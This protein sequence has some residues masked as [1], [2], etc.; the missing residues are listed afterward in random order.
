MPKVCDILSVRGGESDLGFPV[1]LYADD[2]TGRLQI[3]GINE[4]GFA[5]VDIDVGD[6]IQWLEQLAPGAIDCAAL[7]LAL[8]AAEAE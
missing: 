3:R 2:C 5:C 4:G 7:Q 8:A 6:L 1:Q